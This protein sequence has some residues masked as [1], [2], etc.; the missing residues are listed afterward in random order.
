VL[1][2]SDWGYQV[3]AGYDDE[4]THP[5]PGDSGSPWLLA[6]GNAGTRVDMAFAVMSSMVDPGYD[7]M[8]GALVAPRVSRLISTSRAERTA[9]GCVSMLPEGWRFYRCYDRPN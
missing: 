1:D 4:G 2:R 9:L 3:R 8:W 7:K 5:C 6:R